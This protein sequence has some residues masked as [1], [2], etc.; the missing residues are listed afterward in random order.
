MEWEL[1]EQEFPEYTAYL[2]ANGYPEPMPDYFDY[3][4][5]D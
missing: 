3:S 2:E 4:A 1:L 5:E